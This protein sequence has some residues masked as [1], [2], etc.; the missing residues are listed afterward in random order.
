MYLTDRL[1]L[2]PDALRRARRRSSRRTR[3]TCSPFSDDVVIDY[4]EPVTLFERPWTG[5]LF[6][7]DAEQLLRSAARGIVARH[8]DDA[9]LRRAARSCSRTS[10][11]HTEA[12]S[13]RSRRTT[14]SATAAWTAST[15]SCTATARSSSSEA[16]WRSNG[17][18]QIRG[19]RNSDHAD[20]LRELGDASINQHAPV[21]ALLT[22]SNAIYNEYEFVRQDAR[23]LEARAA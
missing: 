23:L 13:P 18:S 16:L 6:R 19:V 8:A 2:R 22:V 15:R 21:P 4:D 11:P 1:V 3:V 14:A 9:E 10:R 7:F 12:S 17:F 5:K 20:F